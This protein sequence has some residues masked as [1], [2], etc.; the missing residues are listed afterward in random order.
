[1]SYTVTRNTSSADC[2]PPVPPINHDTGEAYPLAMQFSGGWKWC[3]AEDVS[4]CVAVLAGDPS[5]VDE[6]DAQARLITRIKTAM[7]LAVVVQAEQIHEAQCDGRWVRL[8][9]DE[10]DML[11]AVRTTQPAGLYADLFGA[12]WWLAAVPLVVVSTGYIAGD[13]PLPLGGPDRV[14]VL[15]PISDEELLESAADI[16]VIR[17]MTRSI[18][19]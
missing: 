5:Y 19:E 18:G 10:K 16:G 8:T 1:M 7:R 11:F 15:N 13:K 4:E 3:W 2:H 14:W 12:P 17:L 9:A 6:P